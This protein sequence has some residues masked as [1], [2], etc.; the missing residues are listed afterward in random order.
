MSRTIDE[1]VVSMQFDNAQF[2]RNVQTS[3]GTLNKLKQSLNLTGAAKGLEDVNAAARGFDASPISNGIE[4]IRAKFSALEVMAVTALANITNSAVNAGK[5]LVKAFTIDPI[6]SGFQEYETQINAV[7]TILA[8]TESKG[9]TLQDVNRALAELN[10]YADKTIYNFTEMTRNIGTF[11]AAGVDLKTSVSAI[12]GIANL[13]AVS[14]S[15]S[16]QASTAMY[17]LSQA[18]ASG[19]VK[20]MDWNSVVNAGMGGQVFQDA[21]KETARVH[22]IAIDDMI[23]SEGS[24]RETLQKGWLT[25][26]ILTETLNHFTMAAEEGTEE[27]E[28]YKKSLMDTGYSEEQAAAILKLANT[29]T[30]AATKVK[31]FSQLMDTLKESAQSGW[32]KSWEILIGDFEEAKGFLTDVSDKLGAMI[33]ESADARNEMLSGGLSS[34]WKQLL[35]AGI[36]DEESY[37]DTLKSIAKEH[38]V[39]IDDMI[40]AEKKLDDSLTDSE[41]FQKALKTGFKDGKLSA[42]MLTESVHKMAD[43]MSNMSAKE[44][45]AAGYTAEYVKQIQD[46]SAGLKDGSISMDDFVNKIQRPSG[47]EN[48][49]QVLW[50]S[51]DGLMNIIIP[52]KEAFHDIFPATTGEQVYQFTERIRDLTSKFKD[53]TEKNAPALK[54]TFKGLFSI[55]KIGVT[56]VKAVVKGITQL[57]GKIIGLSGGLLSITGL[58]GDWIS[59]IAK[60]ITETNL[61]GKVIDVVVGFLGKAID[62]IKEFGS[63]LKGKFEA[64]GFE[65]FLNI[66]NTLWTGIKKVGLAIVKVASNI[67]KALGNAFRNGDMKSL[68]DLVNGGIITTILLKIKNWVSGFKDLAGEGKSFVDTVKDVFGTV[69]DSLT[70]WQNNLKVDTIKAIAISIGI[71]AAAL[72]VLSSIDPEK[73]GSALGGI[74]VLFLELTGVMKGFDKLAISGKGVT[75]VVPLMLSISIA[76]LI[77]AAAVKTLGDLDLGA[78]AKGLVGVGV[79]LAELVGAAKLMSMGGKKIVKG[80]SQMI[81]MAAALKIMASVCKDLSELSWEGIAKGVAGIGG[82]LAVFAGFAELMKLIKPKKMMSSAASLILIGVAM[83]IFADVCA[84]FGQLEWGSLG[85]AGAAIAGI[86]AIAAGFALLAGLSSKMGKSA[87]ALILISA[88]MEIFAD[89]CNK[90]GQME[91]GDLGKAGAAIGGI[92]ALAA[93]FVLLA[94]LSSQM[95]ASVACLTIMAVAMEIFADICNKFSQMNWEELAKAGVAI[96]GIL[97]LAAG[98]ALL[99]GLAPGMLS[100]SAALLVMA[101]ALT[102]LTPVLIMLGKLS[103]G[104]IGK[105][106][107][108][109]AGA[110]LV[111]GVAGIML[112]PIVPSI[113]ALSGAIALLGV[114]CLA[115]GIGVAA[116]A[117]GLMALATLTAAGA[118]AI[119][120]ALHIIIVGILELIPAMIN[121]LTDAVVALCQVFIRSIPAI[122][123]AIKALI[124]ELTNVLVE[125]I[126]TLANGALK[127]VIGVLDALVTYAPQIVSGLVNLFIGLI[128]SLATHLPELVSSMVNFLVLLFDSIASNIAPLIESWGRLFGAIFQGMADVI[129]SVGDAIRNS[130]EGLAEVFD[131]VFGSIAEVITSV[132]D[133]IRIVLDGIAGIIDSIGNAALNAGTGFQKFADGVETITE[134]NLVDMAASMLAVS[135]A[136]GGITSKSDKLSA[137]GEGMKQIADGTKLSAAAFNVMAAGITKVTATLGSIGS[138]ATASMSALKSSVA[139]SATCFTSLSTS[140]ALS[141]ANVTA[142]I[143][144]MAT[145]CESAAKTMSSAFSII[146]RAFV[147]NLANGIR[148]GASHIKAIMMSLLTALM[149][150]ARSW[151]AQFG[152][153]GRMIMVRFASGV[154]SG[155]SVAKSV[156]STALSS[157]ASTASGYYANFYDAGSYVAQGFANGIKDNRYKAEAQARIMAQNAATAAAKALKINSPSK[158]FRAIAYS[159][160]EGFA[161]GINRK[162]WMGKEA[163]VSMAKDTLRGTS[164]TIA[165]VAT[166]V[167]DG[168]DAEP[169]IRPVLDLS[170]VSKGASDLNSMLETDPSIGLM[171]NVRSVSSMMNNRQNGANDDVISA[172]HDLGNQISKSSGDTYSINGITY[173]GD[174]DVSDAIRTLV[175]AARIEGRT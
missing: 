25:S 123:K 8:N 69:G 70:A 4:T 79:L 5:N 32:T 39:S 109:L 95:F 170:A 104:E 166:L 161:Q 141:A 145:T 140:A 63:Y 74:T 61:F 67:G 114:G 10:T 51:F 80:A 45:E 132:G 164:Q 129:T 15:T 111:I 115:A 149:T 113:L 43:K 1:K 38:S 48:I 35:D 162:S 100:S 117:S 175:R 131:S 97:A 73:L 153:I 31:T 101:A 33:G 148:S 62:A 112:A 133:S 156:L 106:L 155:S 24:F 142:S 125:C 160:P 52:I 36:A 56:V 96:G 135:T 86:L 55:L 102:V 14:G 98:F 82:L 19:T 3:M 83:E 78:L 58:L 144:F 172:I 105:G 151:V 42:D 85:K 119:V 139:S 84:K 59:G 23:K 72:W 169:T 150:V 66:L 65:S 126:P 16:Q 107:L 128:D 7:Q 64:P 120:A 29:A 47:R 90:F 92:L 13:A 94:G 49:I 68:L 21:L 88:A 54:S 53:L 174:S 168:I 138:I 2:E 154:R 163:V 121:A 26:D 152:S 76:V 143:S 81:L 173:S 50:N 110:F 6:K 165:K 46:L 34:G 44:L 122:S 158:V 75:K 12:K 28:A 93:G 137:A 30:D 71:L 130:L 22:G 134:L 159:I 57:A 99:A 147:A 18:L 127:M 116:F 118:T 91:W 103:L 9:S 40:A 136:I 37:K 87:T 17:Q 108:A 124:L 77:L 60:S 167:S 89:V 41:A 157:M 27:W 11:T 20:L 171:S 146:G